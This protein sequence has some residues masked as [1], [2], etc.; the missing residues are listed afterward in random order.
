MDE[1]VDYIMHRIKVTRTDGANFPVFSSKAMERLAEAASFVP[2]VIN[3][4]ADKALLV[5]YGEG[6][7]QVA[8][9]HVDM[10][11]KDTPHLSFHSNARKRWLRR[12]LV[13]AAA[14][15]PPVAI[16]LLLVFN[17]DLQSWM[18]NQLGR[19]GFQHARPLSSPVPAQPQAQ[20]APAASVGATQTAAEQ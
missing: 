14:A 19:F 17:S 4:L 11:V 18:R 10:A 13:S 12:A 16:I 5:G 1:A 20:S 15:A 2:R 9:R 3:I 7:T 8:P 6:A